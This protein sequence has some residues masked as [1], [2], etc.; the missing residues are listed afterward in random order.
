MASEASEAA[1]MPH[2]RLLRIS[3]SPRTHILDTT[4]LFFIISFLG[5]TGGLSWS[6]GW[7]TLAFY[8]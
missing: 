2:G 3:F 1:G 4:R 7:Q 5:W 8:G 6:V